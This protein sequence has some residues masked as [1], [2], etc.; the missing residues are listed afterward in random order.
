ML[1]IY[2]CRKNFKMATETMTGSQ[3][4]QQHCMCY[5]KCDNMA[6]IFLVIYLYY[7]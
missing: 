7:D 4:P 5:R 6:Y 3:N 2:K 1:K